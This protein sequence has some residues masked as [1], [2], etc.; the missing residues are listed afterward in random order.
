MIDAWLSASRDHAV[1]LVQDRLEQS[2][3]GVEA[4]RV[5]DRVVGAEELAERGLQLVVH[6]L[7][8]ADEAHRRHAVA[9]GVERRVR[10]LH[11][12]AGGRPGRGSCW[13]TG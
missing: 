4:R 11:Q 1:L 9:V 6:G 8:A 3:V 13:R 5:Q 10:R 12:L 7:G 2:A